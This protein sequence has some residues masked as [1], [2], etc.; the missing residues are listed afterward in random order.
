M[1]ISKYSSEGWWK[2]V[3]PGLE[4]KYTEDAINLASNY[5]YI[6]T[7]DWWLHSGLE[8]QYTEIA[9]DWASRDGNIEVLVRRMV[10][11][12]WHS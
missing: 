4:L 1:D 11:C 8:L 12:I 7:L 2:S 10:A 9:M 5:S 3:T 6:E